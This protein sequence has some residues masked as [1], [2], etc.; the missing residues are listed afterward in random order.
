MLLDIIA[1]VAFPAIGFSKVES[2][3][4][5]E[6]KENGL[7]QTHILSTKEAASLNLGLPVALFS[8]PENFVEFLPP[9]EEDE[10]FVL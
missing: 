9:F 4:K 1:G 7:T 10:F 2:G 8:Q 6:W 3:Q 5:V